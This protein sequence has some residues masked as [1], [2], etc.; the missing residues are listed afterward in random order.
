MV[1]GFDCYRLPV[2]RAEVSNNSPAR[3]SLPWRCLLRVA[4]HCLHCCNGCRPFLLPSLQGLLMSA[5]WIG[6][7]CGRCDPPPPFSSRA[8][9]AIHPSQLDALCL[10]GR[11]G[12]PPWAECGSRPLPDPVMP[13]RRKSNLRLPPRRSS[14]PW[15]IMSAPTPS[16]RLIA[17]TAIFGCKKQLSCSLRGYKGGGATQA[18]TALGTGRT[19]VYS[20]LRF[21]HDFPRTFWTRSSMRRPESP[22]KS[23][24]LVTVGNWPTN[25]VLTKDA[26]L[27]RRSFGLE[28]IPITTLCVCALCCV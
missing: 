28:I 17:S 9:R 11:Q 22:R 23:E 6:A 14:P 19:S 2:L 12:S 7:H 3:P 20:C 5:A 10:P 15:R 8:P 18:G 27:G 25:L 24:R 4:L 26:P 1:V 16:R 21:I 13:R